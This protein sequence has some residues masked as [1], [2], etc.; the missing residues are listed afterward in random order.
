MKIKISTKNLLKTLPFLALPA[1]V[2]ML[3]LPLASATTSV[4]KAEAQVAQ[5]IGLQVLETEDLTL[6]ADEAVIKFAMKNN[7][8]E[9][10]TA[11]VSAFTNDTYGLTI[12]ASTTS[13]AENA[14][15]TSTITDDYIAPVAANSGT[16]KIS[17]PLATATVNGETKQIASWGIKTASGS[18]YNPLPA[19]STPTQLAKSTNLG[20]ITTSFDIAVRTA[21]DTAAG[22]YVADI[23]L[24]AVGNYQPVTLTYYG[25]TPISQ[26]YAANKSDN[27]NT[28]ATHLIA[29][30]NTSGSE[31][32]NFNF[33][34][35]GNGTLA[36]DGSTYLI[37]GEI[38]Y[39]N[40]STDANGNIACGD[41]IVEKISEI[42]TRYESALNVTIAREEQKSYTIPTAQTTYY[43]STATTDAEKHQTYENWVGRVFLGWTTN[44]YKADAIS[45]RLCL[46]NSGEVV[47]GGTYGTTDCAFSDS[48][49]NAADNQEDMKTGDPISI[50]TDTGALSLYAVWGG[51]AIATLSANGNM[52][53]AV[54]TSLDSTGGFTLS[55]DSDIVCHSSRTRLVYGQGTK[56]CSLGYYMYDNVNSSGADYTTLVYTYY[57][58]PVMF[59]SEGTMPGYDN[60]ASLN[61]STKSAIDSGRCTE[62]TTAN[63]QTTANMMS[64]EYETFYFESTDP[65]R[66][67]T[68]LEFEYDFTPVTFALTP[69]L[70]SAKRNNLAYLTVYSSSPR[71]TRTSYIPVGI[72]ADS[73]GNKYIS[74]VNFDPSFATYRPLSTVQWFGYTGNLT[75]NP[76]NNGSET[77]ELRDTTWK[78][79]FIE[80]ADEV[81]PSSYGFTPYRGLN[82]N[83]YLSVNLTTT[84]KITL[85][86]GL[87]NFNDT[88]NTLRSTVMRR[89][90]GYYYYEQKEDKHFNDHSFDNFIDY[91]TSPSVHT[92]ANTTLAEHDTYGWTNYGNQK[93]TS[94]TNFKNLNTEY[95]LAISGMFMCYAGEVEDPVTLD[96]ADFNPSRFTVEPN[97]TA[98]F[99]NAGAYSSNFQIINLSVD[100]SEY[101][102]KNSTGT[103]EFYFKTTTDYA[104]TIKKNALTLADNFRGAAA[105]STNSILDL[106]GV[107]L[108]TPAIEESSATS[109]LTSNITFS[110]NFA[111]S[112]FKTITLPKVLQS[113]IADSVETQIEV[114]GEFYAAEKLTTINKNA[115]WLNELI[116]CSNTSL[117]KCNNNTA[118]ANLISYGNE[119]GE[120]AGVTN[121]Q[122]YNKRS[123]SNFAGAKNIS[124]PNGTTL[125]NLD[126]IGVLESGYL[127]L[128]LSRD[129]DTEDTTKQYFSS[130][131]LL[132]NTHTENI[133][134]FSVVGSTKARYVA[135]D[136]YAEFKNIHRS[137]PYQWTGQYFTKTNN[138]GDNGTTAQTAKNIS[139]VEYLKCDT[140]VYNNPIMK[141]VTRNYTDA[142]GNAVTYQAPDILSGSQGL[143]TCSNS[144]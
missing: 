76:E 141:T 126:K 105:S 11:S 86:S 50:T 19:A 121:T 33:F 108:S 14:N 127:Y 92:A 138:N 64:F 106:S 71:N 34:E 91:S 72:T 78:S 103:S 8:F 123:Y 82:F 62:G 133:Y 6:E 5:S 28:T 74:S 55:D 112:G 36:S 120:Y 129:F 23:L 68:T 125:S 63:L 22:T 27:V 80:N 7:D 59:L 70:I 100:A 118:M 94:I 81:Y 98:V 30:D 90:R 2:L 96:L 48:S 143:F 135:D 79:N 10:H 9:T 32:A 56:T 73:N 113:T 116:S 110:F 77:Y 67:T 115:T 61:C 66:T 37:D 29:Y 93:T 111:N 44:P 52:D 60:Y 25:S 41:E 136:D 107:T 3:L 42:D 124:T 128:L 49:F 142:N 20:T 24:T 114:E 40:C 130:Y 51:Y 16:T 35:L 139:T 69:N 83:K 46:N 1:L 84:E 21:S 140:A 95:V 131:E 45:N 65:R 122:Y 89:L 38:A 132:T 15:I 117:S 119:S 12:L 4:L 53:F 57:V 31:D 109:G 88:Y 101:L 43:N 17:F 102:Y 39:T 104:N 144:E 87:T 99:A 97:T 85:Q 18:T 137:Y 58:P 13:S 75:T 26:V 54:A 134:N 47:S